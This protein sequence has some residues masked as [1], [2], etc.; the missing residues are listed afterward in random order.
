MEQSQATHANTSPRGCNPVLTLGG[1]V[2]QGTG[3]T[4]LVTAAVGAGLT[5]GWDSLA[6][7]GLTTVIVSLLPCVLMC[8]VGLCASRMGKKDAAAVP[9]QDA[10]PPATEAVRSAAAGAELQAPAPGERAT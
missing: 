8:A 3:I 5:F 4:V 6:A 10:Q 2:S 9:L 1:R 7:L